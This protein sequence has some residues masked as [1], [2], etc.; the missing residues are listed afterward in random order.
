MFYS[1]KSCVRLLSDVENEENFQYDWVF[2]SRFDYAINRK[3]NEEILQNLEPNAFYSPHVITKGNPHCHC[4]FN[5]GGSKLMK[6]YSSTFDN[7]QKFGEKGI[8][9]ANEAMTYNQL[10]EN[11]IDVK[12]FDL[13]NQFPP[14]RHSACWHSLWGHR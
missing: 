7:L 11:D 10:I 6:I 8:I 12:E 13:H 4:D 1:I 14:S 2:R 3:F 9:L 5:F